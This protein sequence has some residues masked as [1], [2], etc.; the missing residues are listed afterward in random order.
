MPTIP[1]SLQ[2]V[3]W[4]PITTQWRRTPVPRLQESYT[5]QK[6]TINNNNNISKNN[7]R[8]QGELVDNRF[9]IGFSKIDS[10]TSSIVQ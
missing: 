2:L 1:A 7:Q 10:S 4:N 9:S 6:K 8:V 3:Q 5:I